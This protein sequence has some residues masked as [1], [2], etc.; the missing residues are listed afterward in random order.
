MSTP[1]QSRLLSPNLLAAAVAAAA[2][3]KQLFYPGSGLLYLVPKTPPQ[4]ENTRSSKSGEQKND[5]VYMER[6][7]PNGMCKYHLFSLSAA[8]FVQLKHG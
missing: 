6:V 5:L 4:V 3:S 2:R 8:S 1:K 7:S